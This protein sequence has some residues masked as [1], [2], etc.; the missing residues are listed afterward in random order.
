MTTIDSTT[1]QRLRG[2]RLV[3]VSDRVSR[4]V[5]GSGRVIGHV[6]RAGDGDDARFRARRFRATSG[7]FVDLGGFW[8]L[9][10]AVAA[11]HDSR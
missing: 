7:G 6:A 1:I 4:V 8:H 10:D 3:V 11:L 9:E 5:D 2:Y